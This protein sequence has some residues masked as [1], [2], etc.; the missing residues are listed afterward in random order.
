VEGADCGWERPLPLDDPDEP[1]GWARA[2][3]FEE[4]AGAFDD[5]ADGAA[6]ERERPDPSDGAGLAGGACPPERPG[7]EAVAGAFP[8]AERGTTAAA[9]TGRI[10]WPVAAATEATGGPK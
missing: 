10:G 7:V 3:A 4:G 6:E 5:G 8:G 1:P 9:L 2:G